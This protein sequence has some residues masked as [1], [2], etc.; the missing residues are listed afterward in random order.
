MFRN[1]LSI[2]AIGAALASVGTA[3]VGFT[4]PA[5]QVKVNA[6]RNAKRGLLNDVVLPQSTSFWGRKGAGIGMAQQQRA[7]KKARNVRR[8]KAASHG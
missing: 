3:A 6:P 4:Q 2:L 5:P 1:R 8:H 7:A